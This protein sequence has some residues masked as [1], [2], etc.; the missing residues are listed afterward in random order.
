MKHDCDLCC[1]GLQIW[2]VSKHDKVPHYVRQISD[3]CGRLSH[4]LDVVGVGTDDT[5]I[6]LQDDDVLIDPVG[7]SPLKLFLTSREELAMR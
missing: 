5:Q 1:F 4:P 6:L 3:S 7:N 2:F